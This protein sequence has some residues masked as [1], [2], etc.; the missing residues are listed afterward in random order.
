[1]RGHERNAKER[2]RKKAEIASPSLRK[3]RQGQH[4]KRAWKQREIAEHADPGTA[5]DKQRIT[6]EIGSSS[7]DEQEARNRSILA[8]FVTTGETQPGIS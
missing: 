6:P 2:Q 8:I 7:I 3:K 4:R 1:M 5:E